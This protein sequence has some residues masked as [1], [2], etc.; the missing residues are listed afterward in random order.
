MGGIRRVDWPYQPIEKEPKMSIIFRNETGH[1]LTWNTANGGVSSRDLLAMGYQV[2]RY[3]P[4]TRPVIGRPIR[5]SR[6]EWAE[7]MNATAFL[8]NGIAPLL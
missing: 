7:S 5:D 3:I 6:R 8:P 1:E 4:R 2:V